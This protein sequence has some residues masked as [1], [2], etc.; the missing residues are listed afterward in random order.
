MQVRESMSWRGWPSSVSS[1]M[2]RTRIVVTTMVYWPFSHVTRLL[3]RENV[4]VFI[5]IKYISALVVAL[6]FGGR[7]V[8]IK[9]DFSQIWW[10][11]W[12]CFAVETGALF[13]LSG[14]GIGSFISCILIWPRALT[15]TNFT[16]TFYMS[17]KRYRVQTLTYIPHQL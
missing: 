8:L 5:L 12:S 4:I 17:C 7:T 9:A 6:N 14:A 1:L 13:I 2:T 11:L 3:I 15:C 16:Q 10:S